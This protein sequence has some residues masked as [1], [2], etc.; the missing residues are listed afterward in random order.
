MKKKIIFYGDSN[1]YGY[2]PANYLTGRYEKEHIWT[3]MLKDKLGAG[4]MVMNEGMNGRQLP[5]R[6]EELEYVKILLNRLDRRDYFVIMLG[7]NDILLTLNPD[8]RRA[9]ERMEYFM[10]W[11]SS[12]PDHPELILI[13]PPYIACDEDDISDTGS[14]QHFFK[15]H[16]ALYSDMPVGE[17]TSNTTEKLSP[18]TMGGEASERS[19]YIRYHDESIH[20]NEA[21]RRIAEKYQ[22]RF[23]DAAEWGVELSYDKVHFSEKGHRIFA[24][25]MYMNLMQDK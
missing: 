5:K 1:T 23:A 21:F 14:G 15:T 7:T 8:A 24:E 13:A 19:L 6:K 9:E 18:G 12:R 3:Y 20:M 17:E 25:Q 4:W 16:P 10:S 22:V 2:D 11:I